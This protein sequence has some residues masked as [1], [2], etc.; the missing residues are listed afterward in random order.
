VNHGTENVF[1]ANASGAKLF[2]VAPLP[3]KSWQSDSALSSSS[4]VSSCSRYGIEHAEDL[5]LLETARSTHATEISRPLAQGNH[6]GEDLA[7][8]AVFSMF[9][10]IGLEITAALELVEDKLFLH[11]CSVRMAI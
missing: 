10:S 4:G 9:R 7:R 5:L 2:Q 6:G 1:I 8:D 11:G 3:H